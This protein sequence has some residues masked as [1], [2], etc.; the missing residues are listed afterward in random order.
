LTQAGRETQELRHL[1]SVFA[2][3][4]NI[5]FAAGRE[6]ISRWIVS[7][8]PA[9]FCLHGRKTERL[10][11]LLHQVEIVPG[12]VVCRWL[13]GG[14]WHSIVTNYINIH[15]KRIGELTHR[16]CPEFR[17][18]FTFMVKSD[19]D[20]VAIV[21]SPR[22][23]PHYSIIRPAGVTS[24]TD[25]F[26]AL[27]GEKLKIEVPEAFK[28]LSGSNWPPMVPTG[29]WVQASSFDMSLFRCF[30][31]RSPIPPVPNSEQPPKTLVPKKHHT[32]RS[33]RPSQISIHTVLR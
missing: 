4:S 25:V 12:A 22:S 31:Q 14:P 6:R 17:F 24:N 8:Q 18:R 30:S 26:V 20:E 2:C 28:E 10:Q 5:V 3:E 9:F 11:H 1:G 19:I 29:R 15:K 23:T 16:S 33:E 32:Q 7:R 21:P 13:N 27:F